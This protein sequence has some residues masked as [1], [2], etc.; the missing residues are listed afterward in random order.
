[1]F[2]KSSVSAHAGEQADVLPELMSTTLRR[3]QK[4]IHISKNI[5]HMTY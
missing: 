1:M 2:G 3:R 5:Q 4:R